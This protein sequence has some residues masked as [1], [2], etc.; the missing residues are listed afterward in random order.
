MADYINT[1]Y[2]IL[3]ITIMTA[4]LTPLLTWVIA[5]SPSQTK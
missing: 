5:G 1:I 3:I 4:C 2:M